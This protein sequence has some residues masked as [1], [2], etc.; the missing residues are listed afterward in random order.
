MGV[1]RP[2]PHG[3]AEGLVVDLHVEALV[4]HQH[5][6]GCL[7]REGLGCPQLVRDA[8]L[9]AVE[10]VVD[11]R[12]DGRQPVGQ[13]ALRLHRLEPVRE[14]LGDEARRQRTRAPA[15]MRHQRRQERDVVA[16]ALDRE[17]VEGPGLRVDRLQ[18]RRRVGDQLGDHGIVVDRDLAALVDAGV[19]AHRY[20]V[21]AA[22]LRRPVGDEAAGR[23]QEVA[24]RILGVDAAFHR[25]AVE[26]DLR[27]GDAQRLARRNPDHLLDEV[28]AGDHL[29]D[30]MLDLQP[31]VHLEEIEGLVLPGD[32][33]DGAGRVV[34]DRL[35]QRDRLLAHQ[36]P[37]GG[38]EQR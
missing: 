9:A 6:A 28:D 35:G 17:G 7:E 14:L 37:R 36:P 11:R 38:V 22:L 27:L 8:A 1:V 16:D 33:L 31:G 30:R 24:G 12:G 19:V 20:P 2:E 5:H 18:P 29:G 10:L 25:P 13:L 32:E 26:P 21:G 23:G 4:T 34:A 15:L 3:R